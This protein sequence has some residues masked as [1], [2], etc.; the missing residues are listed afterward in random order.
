MKTLISEPYLSIIKKYLS[1]ELG[2]H[3]SALRDSEL[4]RK[5]GNAAKDFGYS[6]IIEFINW[7]QSERI[8]RR[9][10]EKLAS[11]LTIGETYFLRE[12]AAFDFLKQEYLRQYIYDN[13]KSNK[14]LKIWS[15]GCSSGEE[16]YSLA[17]FIREMLPDH[18]DWTISITGTDINPVALEKA[19]KGIYSKWSFRNTPKW[20]LKY[21]EELDANSYKICDC[22]REMVSFKSHN[23]ASDLQLF[24]DINVIF[25]RNVL[26]YFPAELI[27]RVTGKFYDSLAEEGLLVLSPVEVSL[28]I[29]DRFIRKY[30]AGRTF[31]IKD[32]HSTAPF[33]HNGINYEIHREADK[34]EGNKSAGGEIEELDE[35]ERIRFLYEEGLYLRVENLIKQHNELEEDLPLAYLELLAN[36]YCKM[37]KSEK[38]IA[39]CKRIIASGKHL[40]VMSNLLSEMEVNREDCKQ[41]EEG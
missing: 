41:S 21:V 6:D 9:D 10:L 3:Y 24:Y 19:R 4:S 28:D 40:Q 35:Y 14:T 26:I 18:S 16:V 39:L 31:F 30:Y 29:C 5:L 32:S 17:G 20:F 25:C 12:P 15:A 11:H 38:A 7:L 2:L 22:L 34:G 27:K 1:K 36:T 8:S 13:R 23:L 33:I 37:G